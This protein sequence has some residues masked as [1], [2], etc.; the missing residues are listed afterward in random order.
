MTR[1]PAMAEGAVFDVEAGETQHQG[2]DRF[3]RAIDGRRAGR[4][5]AGS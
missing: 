4:G 5:A 1:S 3:E 2:L